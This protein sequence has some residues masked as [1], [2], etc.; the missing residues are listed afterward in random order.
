MSDP[1]DYYD[2]W[3]DPAQD[4]TEEEFLGFCPGDQD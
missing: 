2:E 3:D 1:Y 4:M